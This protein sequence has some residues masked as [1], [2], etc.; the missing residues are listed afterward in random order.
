MGLFRR[1]G[2]V[3]PFADRAGGDGVVFH[4]AGV[5][6]KSSA[7]NLRVPG[8]KRATKAVSLHRGSVL[9][10]GDHLSISYR[11]FVA[12]DGNLRVDPGAA[13]QV[14]F[15]A[16]GVHV[17]IDITRA[18]VGVPGKNEGAA[19]IDVVT[20]IPAEVL[21]RLGARAVA[22]SPVQVSGIARRI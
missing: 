6:I 17:D 5:R 21:A 1:N 7:T 14:S 18:L 13:A 12:I 2:P 11:K 8:A 22:I 4:A 19:R 16:T 15:D 9:V 3:D 10:T 20:E